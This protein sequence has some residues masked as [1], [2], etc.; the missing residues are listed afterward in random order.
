MKLHNRSEGDIY[1]QSKQIRN[2]LINLGER[3]ETI[4]DETYLSNENV[5][6]KT[7]SVH[8]VLREGNIFVEYECIYKGKTESVNSGITVQR[9]SGWVWAFQEEMELL[10]LALLLEREY[11]LEV[12]QKGLYEGIVDTSGWVPLPETGDV[13]KGYLVP[14][15]YL[16]AP[17]L[18]LI[19]KKKLE[20]MVNFNFKRLSPLPTM[21]NTQNRLKSIRNEKNTVRKDK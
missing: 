6:I 11:L 8:K 3:Y 17:F 15:W 19:P 18:A 4:L 21:R 14:L 20:E 1:P 9:S 12:I 5:E 13:V 10:P 2:L 16:L 7:E